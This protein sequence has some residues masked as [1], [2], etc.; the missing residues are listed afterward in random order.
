MFKC[1]IKMTV[2][3]VYRIKENALEQCQRGRVNEPRNVAIYLCRRL[4]GLRLSEIGRA[5]GLEKYS[6]VSSVVLRTEGML[7]QSKSLQKRVK[8]IR[9]EIEKSQAKT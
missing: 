6:L 8:T 3:K 2:S 1:F 5:F 7:F 4:S 9:H